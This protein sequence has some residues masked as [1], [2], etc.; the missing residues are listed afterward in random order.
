MRAAAATSFGGPSAVEVVD[1]P[2]PVPGDQHVIVDVVAAGLTFPDVLQTRGTHQI[3]HELP[4]VLGTE[5]AGRVRHAPPGSGFDVGQ[6]V[7][8]LG[9]G[10]SLAEQMAA[11]PSMVLPLPDDVAFENGVAIP[12][13]YLTALFGLRDRAGLRPDDVV[14]VHGAGS[15]VGLAAVEVAVLLGASVV[16]VA[17][18]EEKRRQASRA[19]ADHAVSPDGFH[20]AVTELL[21]RTPVDVVFDPVGGDRFVDSLRLLRACGRLLVVG[22]AAGMIPEVRVNRLLLR[23]LSVVGVNWGAEALADPAFAHE[24]WDTAVPW[25]RAGHFRPE[26]QVLDGLGSVAEGLTL[27]ETRSVAGKLVVRVAP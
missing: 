23:N 2:A 10:G 12:A 8:A 15:G 13:N 7:V 4:F 21:G 26:V 14:L 5:A 19:G 20:G 6:R 27:L 25:V 17:S 24:Q 3:R 22:F 18:D 1:A 11:P 16:A 9:P